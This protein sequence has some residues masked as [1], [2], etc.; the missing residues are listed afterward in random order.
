MDVAVTEPRQ[1][2]LLPI[3]Q[4]HAAKTYSDFKHK[5][6]TADIAES[7]NRF[8]LPIVLESFGAYNEEGLAA[9]KSIASQLAKRSNSSYSITSNS[10]FHHL[11]II[12]QKANAKALLYRYD[13]EIQLQ[14]KISLPTFTKNKLVNAP[15]ISKSSDTPLINNQPPFLI[16]H[17]IDNQSCFSSQIVSQPTV[18]D[19]SNIQKKFHLFPSHDNSLEDLISS[20]RKESSPKHYAHISSMFLTGEKVRRFLTSGKKFCIG[21]RNPGV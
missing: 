19:N 4:G 12:L 20:F 17:N 1:E 5:K 18:F 13:P 2:K 3:T 8:L 21:P 7:P 11:S 16:E 6:Y 10:I 15:I 9:I 14:T